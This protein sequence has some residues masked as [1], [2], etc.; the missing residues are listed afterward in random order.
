MRLARHGLLAH[1][2]VSSALVLAPEAQAAEPPSMRTQGFPAA[3]SPHNG[4]RTQGVRALILGENLDTALRSKVE[5]ELR[6]AG[7]EVDAVRSTSDV[8]VS[9]ELASLARSNHARVLFRMLEPAAGVE[10]W[11]VDPRSDM[12]LFRELVSPKTSDGGD[13]SVM[14]L[15]AV[16]IAHA[17][18]LV[19]EAREAAAAPP[20]VAEKTPQPSVPAPIG[21]S[22]GPSVL[23]SPGGLTLSGGALFEIAVD[24]SERVSLGAVADVPLVPSQLHSAEGAAQARTT[25]GGPTVTYSFSGRASRFRPYVGAGVAALWVHLDG[26]AVAPNV[27]GKDDVFTALPFA[28]TGIGV[29][30]APQLRLRIDAL[31]GEFSRRRVAAFGLPLVMGTM[32]VEVAWR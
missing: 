8:D 28:R 1:L 29:G 31:A 21:F 11:L 15:R 32:L 3:A 17:G 14:A 30:L 10:V 9:N 13:Q 2:C 18:L 20:V 6:V 23:G 12:L 7:F 24:A 22:V 25:L 5:A 27:S 26:N 16:E 4:L 19:I